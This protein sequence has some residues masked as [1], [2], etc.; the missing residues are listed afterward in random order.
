M[1]FELGRQHGV[2]DKAIG[3]MVEALSRHMSLFP[4]THSDG[5][6]DDTDDH[7][8]GPVSRE[9][10]TSG[11]LGLMREERSF[12]NAVK[13]ALAFVK[14]LPDRRLSFVK[15]ISAGKFNPPEPWDLNDAPTTA[16]PRRGA[17]DGD[18][19][20]TP[21]A[22]LHAAIAFYTHL[23]HALITLATEL[24][25][26]LMTG[27]APGHGAAHSLAPALFAYINLLVLKEKAG[28]ERAIISGQ[29]ALYHRHGM[30]ADTPEQE[31]E[32]FHVDNFGVRSKEKKQ[33][34]FANST[35]FI[36]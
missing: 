21:V 32:N 28:I 7:E 2:A 34:L 9:T 17:D 20:L 29:L 26:D 23:H 12:D 19:E 35:V 18:A 30:E 33:H 14:E 8:R 16:E 25:T 11:P 3:L 22:E 36:R 5:D 10:A 15:D 31:D 24:C 13:S 4:H 1:S 27:E 6:D